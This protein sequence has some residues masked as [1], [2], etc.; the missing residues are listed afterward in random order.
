VVS[1][2]TLEPVLTV[3]HHVCSDDSSKADPYTATHIIVQPDT[4][5]SFSLH[6]HITARMKTTP[7]AWLVL[8]VCVCV[9]VCVMTF[10]DCIDSNVLSF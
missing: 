8:Y 6:V 7:T 4:L 3:F 9:C 10:L 1:G 5:D 2:F